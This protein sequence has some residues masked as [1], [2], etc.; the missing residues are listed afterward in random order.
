MSV[1]FQLFLLVPFLALAYVRDKRLG[2]LLPALLWLASTAY[3]YYLGYGQDVS[4]FAMQTGAPIPPSNSIYPFSPRN[5][6]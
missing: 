5:N 1:D 3:A 6:G 4:E 2:Y